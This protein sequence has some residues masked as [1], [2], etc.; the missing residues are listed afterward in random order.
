MSSSDPPAFA[1]HFSAF[2]ARYAEYRP[3]YPDAL[4]D[5]LAD[6]CA[7]HQ[8]AWDIGCGNGQ[9]SVALARRF[10]RVIATDPAQAQLDHAVADPRVEYRRAPAEASG[11]ADA[12][13]D[14]A[15]AAQAAHWFD[16]P[17]FVPEVGRVVRPGGL[18][19]LVTYRNAA[20]DGPAGDR[21]AAFYDVIEPYWPDGRRHVNNHYAEL[22]LP[23]PEV[24]APPLEMA[25]RWTRDELLGYVS[26]WSS[27]ARYVAA[28]G[29][30]AV[31]ELRRQLAETWP[32]DEPRRVHWGLTV[33]LARR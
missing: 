28:H 24:A 16:W 31:D 7:G 4:T 26:T 3:R 2:A 17:R 10:A 8:V 25:A 6:R 15:V 23:W 11:L 13:C 29:T 18:V 9:L 32:A 19:A 33:K 22:T 21:L 20:V 14:L 1:D 30:A 5:A 27:T 12:S